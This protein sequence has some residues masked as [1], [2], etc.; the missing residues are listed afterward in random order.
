M[1]ILFLL[2]TLYL[3]IRI[4]QA[5]TGWMNAIEI[6]MGP[7][8]ENVHDQMAKGFSSAVSTAER[9]KLVCIQC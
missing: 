8:E 4:Q 5:S 7:S 9:A 2:P 6:K 1:E 3:F